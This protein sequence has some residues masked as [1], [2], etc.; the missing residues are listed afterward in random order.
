[1][2][3]LRMVPGEAGNFVWYGKLAC[4]L[5]SKNALRLQ[6]RALLVAVVLTRGGG[7]T[8]RQMP[9]R[10]VTRGESFSDQ[11]IAR[12]FSRAQGRDRALGRS[13]REMLTHIHI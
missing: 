8:H 9:S 7:C 3:R 5:P 10:Q 2:R 6:P 13:D 11:Q 1:M 4:G 12:G